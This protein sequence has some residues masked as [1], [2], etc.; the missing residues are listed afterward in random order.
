MFGWYRVWVVSCSGGVV[1]GR[2]RVGGGF[3]SG[4]CGVGEEPCWGGAVLGG[5]WVWGG[6]V[7]GGGACWGVV[8]RVGLGGGLGGVGVGVRGGVVLDSCGAWQVGEV[9]LG[10]GVVVGGA[11]WWW[12]E[13]GTMYLLVVLCRMNVCLCL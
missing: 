3:V 2:C 8:G 11:W 1:L 6:A 13:Y 12:L 10:W 7:V 4:R 5:G 9:R